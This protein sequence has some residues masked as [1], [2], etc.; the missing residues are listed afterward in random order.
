M[1]FVRAIRDHIVAMPE[2][3]RFAG[4]DFGD[5]VTRPAIFTIDPAPESCPG[6]LCIITEDPEVEQWGT[7][8]KRGTVASI[9]IRLKGDKSRSDAGLRDLANKIFAWIDR[10]GLT[11]SGWNV[12]CVTCERPSRITDPDGFPE[13]AMNARIRAIG[14]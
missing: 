13:Y 12:V 7:K 8:L 14:E 11:V 1:P 9:N 5:G 4:W 3:P 6:P 10:C 2:S